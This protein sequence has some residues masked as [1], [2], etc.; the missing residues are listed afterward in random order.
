MREILR[1][2][3]F[4]AVF[5][6]LVRHGWS[7]T[8]ITAATGLS[9]T[10]VRAVLQGKQR[11]TS[12]E[13]LERIADGLL[14]ERGLPGLAYGDQPP[15]D[16][17]A[18]GLDA[19]EPAIAIGYRRLERNSSR[20]ASSHRAEAQ[21]ARRSTSPNPQATPLFQL[22]PDIAD[23]TGRGQVTAELTARLT[24]EPAGNA[25]V[26]CVVSG[27]GGVGKTA[28]AVHVAHSIQ[29]VYPDGQLYVDLR[30][31]QAQPADPGQVLGRFLNELGLDAESIPEQTDDRARLYRAQLA[32]R[33]VLVVLDNAADERQVRPL[34]PGNPHCAVVVTSRRRLIGLDSAYQMPLEVMAAEQ[35]RE[36]LAS[37]LGL[38]RA[39]AEPEACQSI[40][41]YC[42]RLPL[43][44]RIAGAR[45]AS[46]PGESLAFYARRLHDERSRLDLLRAGD[47]EVRT[48][49]ALSYESCDE[50]P[51]RAF[52]LLGSLDATTHA[53]M[54]FR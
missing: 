46:R 38:G 26:V 54:P 17:Q 36:M 21:A 28:L 6:F 30:G 53:P 18:A 34:L 37:A 14:I 24:D 19:A 45:L 29:G 25:M 2:R 27:K 47:R 20:R 32:S 15:T 11:I 7:R 52:R 1:E 33:A 31:V 48:T 35:A 5:G 9:E 4:S 43:A 42:G 40:V 12:Y 44:L 22:P 8:S 3:D 10:R 41:R 51:R 13:V 23:F 49:F 39:E 50:D 16:R